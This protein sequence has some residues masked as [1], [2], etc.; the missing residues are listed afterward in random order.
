M[1]P[2]PEESIENMSKQIQ[3][4]ELFIKLIRALGS[5]KWSIEEKARI[6]K[7]KYTTDAKIWHREVA[8]G[9]VLFLEVADYD[10][11]SIQERQKF[12]AKAHEETGQEVLVATLQP[13]GSEDASSETIYW[14]VAS[15]AVEFEASANEL[16]SKLQ[17]VLEQE[18]PGGASEIPT[19]QNVWICQFKPGDGEMQWIRDARPESIIRWRT[20]KKGLPGDMKPGDPVVYWRSIHPE[21]RK[22][23]GGLVGTG[24]IVSTDLESDSTGTN[25]FPTK[26]REFFNEQPIPRDEVVEFAGLKGKVWRGAV[27]EV[28]SSQ[29]M[30]IDELLQNH[31]WQSLFPDPSRPSNEYGQIS[32]RRDDAERDHDA[33]GRA[34]L[35][36]SLAWTFHD[37][38]CTE[39]GYAPF[40]DRIAQQDAPGFLAH[41]DSPWG[42]GKTSF[43]NLIARTLNP[44]L[45]G[46]PPE[47][48]VNLY[49]DRSDMSGLFMSAA[50]Q[51]GNLKN[52]S[53]D[54]Y[55]WDKKARRP[56]IIVPF[57]AWLNQHVD[58]PWWCFYQAIRKTCFSAI[59]KDGVQTVTQ[60]EDG[61]YRT[62]K[63][64]LQKR[65]IHVGKLW[66]RELWWRLTTP[67]VKFQL[68]VAAASVIVFLVLK[69]DGS[70]RSSDIGAV[71]AFL[72]GVGSFFTAFATVAADAVAPGRSVIGEKVV[73]GSADPL[74]RFRRHFAKMMT[75]I[76]RPVLVIIDDIDRCEPR[77]IV[78]MTRGLQTIL[79]SPRIVY[80]MLGDRHWIEQA[81]EIHHKDM[82]NIDVGPEHTFGGRFVE[83][84][85]QLSFVLPS[86]GEHKSDYVREVLNGPSAQQDIAPAGADENMSQVMSLSSKDRE[87]LRSSISD[88]VTAREIDSAGAT[89]LGD[90]ADLNSGRV[91]AY[92]RVIREEIVLRRAAQKKEVEKAIRH[93]IQPLAPYLPGNPRH[94]K[95][96]IN[97][98]SLY[99]NSIVLTEAKYGDAEFGGMRWRQLVIGVVLM[100]GYPKSWT[101]LARHPEWADQLVSGP[102]E[103]ND[104]SGPDAKTDQALTALQNNTNFVALLS[105]TALRDGVDGEVVRTEIT[106]DVV[107]WLN[108]VI[109]IAVG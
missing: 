97:A 107:H 25:R 54:E 4:S 80:L 39:Q 3:E 106:A 29:A 9:L 17:S 6:P 30:K 77:F 14:F 38:W 40:P 99:Q 49:T 93:R 83:K 46:K 35:A 2:N 50:H 75:Q 7:S 10:V 62:E 21:N 100:I 73:L 92:E 53:S 84:A 72:T 12:W 67:K 19:H 101:N 74:M 57:N 65:A 60:N 71:I 51:P 43:A 24:Q 34:P 59:L 85:I 33:L 70:S 76:E 105:K 61:S 5:N 82:K 41:I 79:K 96:I 68:A 104:E 98:I 52:G 13:S 18:N 32:L 37:I 81:F 1:R 47:F 45:D 109:P 26:V 87:H 56:W 58:P 44:N 48:L 27:L 31:G 95:R 103:H 15:R 69:Y 16:A 20:E 89:A 42:G 28:S 8:N 66:L 94:I 108:R 91:K 55:L 90:V 23:R 102:V 22:D 11:G 88:A 36:V 78:E 63:E 64:D 86:I